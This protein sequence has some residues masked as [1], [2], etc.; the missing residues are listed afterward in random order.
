[1]R[2]CDAARAPWS[3][4]RKERSKA[5]DELA[6][7]S[8][9][10]VEVLHKMW[11]LLQLGHPRAQL[12]K[13]LWLP[14]MAGWARTPVEQGHVAASMLIRN[15]KIMDIRLFLPVPCWSLGLAW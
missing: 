6:A 7:G 3:I 4:L 8:A 12:E 5:L 2:V 10:E 14:S 1:M 11:G 15:I 13:G 9:P